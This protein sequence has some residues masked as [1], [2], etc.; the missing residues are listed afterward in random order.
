VQVREA[1]E[2]AALKKA[3]EEA[4]ERLDDDDGDT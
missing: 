3:A 4:G 1:A 2:K